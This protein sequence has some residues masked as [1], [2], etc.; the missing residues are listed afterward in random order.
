MITVKYFLN[1]KGREYFPAWFE[2]LYKVSSEQDGFKNLTY[3][4]KE[5]TPIVTLQF[6]NQAKL[7]NW[8]QTDVHHNLVAKI[9]AFFIK[10]RAVQRQ[11]Y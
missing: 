8:I 6:E 10:P 11:Q 1:S 7:D 9:N 2:E 4:Y 3:Q 5:D